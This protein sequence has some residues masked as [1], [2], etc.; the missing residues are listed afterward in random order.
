M[1][2]CYLIK[3]NYDFKVLYPTVCLIIWKVKRN[4]NNFVNAS[5]MLDD[6]KLAFS[7]LMTAVY[8]MATEVNRRTTE[9]YFIFTFYI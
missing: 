2:Y 5:K 1:L 9:M 3:K 8:L 4:K 6:K 7:S